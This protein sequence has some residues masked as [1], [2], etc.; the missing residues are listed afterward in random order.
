MALGGDAFAVYYRIGGTELVLARCGT[1][2]VDVAFSYSISAPGGI[3]EA[4]CLG[5]TT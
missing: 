4:W 5:I 3:G 2:V 1:L